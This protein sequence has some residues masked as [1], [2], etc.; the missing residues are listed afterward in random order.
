MQYH[1][2]MKSN[3]LLLAI[4]MVMMS[5]HHKQTSESSAEEH[6]VAGVQAPP[7]NP[8]SA[9]FYVSKQVAFGPRV[10][11]MPAHQHCLAW[12]TGKLKTFAD[13]V[14]VQRTTVTSFQNKPLPCINLIA[15]FNPSASSRILLLA[16]WDTRPWADHDTADQDKPIDGADDGASGVAVCLEIARQLHSK[17]PGCGVDILLTDVEDYGSEND[18][19][20][21]GLGTQYWAR[22]P[23]IPSYKANFGILLDMVGGRGSQFRM[24]QVTRHYA[25][26]YA[27]KIWDAGNDLGFSYY[28]PY[29]DMGNVS[30]IDDHYFINTLTNIPTADII[31]LRPDGS[32]PPYHHTHGDN[33]AVI[34]RKT[35]AAVGQTVLSVIYNFSDYE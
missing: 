27:R 24:E 7:F 15:S 5:C 18:N 8:D 1:N 20:S 23:H 13:T 4:L 26:G 32:F 21:W 6:P 29:D 35:L 19:N 34:D 16:H 31:A 22:H 30:I 17:S 11:D 9:Y 12:L 25:G 3:I 10:P 33:M 14:F 28:F 2:K